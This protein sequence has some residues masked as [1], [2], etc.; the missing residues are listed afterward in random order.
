MST[1]HPS[2]AEQIDR[3]AEAVCAG[4]ISPEEM[5]LLDQLLSENLGLCQQYLNYLKLH[6]SL[7]V[8]Q[9]PVPFDQLAAYTEQPKRLL[10]A[11]QLLAIAVTLTVTA[12][13]VALFFVWLQTPSMPV[14][15]VAVLSAD[16]QWDGTPLSP[17]NLVRMGDN[18]FL[19]EGT[20]TF[21]LNSGSQ[22]HLIAPASITI[23]HDMHVTLWDGM[24]TAH[25]P[26]EAV[27]F[28]VRTVDAEIYD[29]GTDFIVDRTDDHE[30][31]VFVKR[32]RVEARLYD[33]SG[34]V[35]EALQ[36]TSGRSA[37]LSVETGLIEESELLLKWGIAWDRVEHTSGGIQQTDGD[38]RTISTSPLVLTEGTHVTPEHFLVIPEK[39][40]V[41]LTEAVNWKTRLGDV[42]LPVG[43]VLDSYLIHYDPPK[44]IKKGVSGTITFHE[45]VLAVLEDDSQL[46]NTD[47]L[48]G[49]DGREWPTM[50]QRGF[51]SEDDIHISDDNK[52]VRL[53]PIIGQEN[54]F[55]QCR[56]LVRSSPQSN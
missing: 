10:K 44:G 22:I 17:G 48:F 19:R 29:L 2:S 43:T 53:H 18:F 26:S 27:G 20:A 23:R 36:L 38:A 24:L 52:T 55:D 51:E 33:N 6:A 32:G 54:Y 28:I 1:S 8:M 37:R 3:L 47:E 39:K 12:A 42:H 13:S 15:R 4:T 35:A 5:S 49:L 40:N 16:A 45:N 41:I 30:T 31:Q 14:G 7:G 21:E 34:N 50:K 25:V 46:Q 11:S 56:V 9:K